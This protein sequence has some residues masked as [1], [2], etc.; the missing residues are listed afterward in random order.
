VD[1][2]A[3]LLRKR[4]AP[5]FEVPAVAEADDEASEMNEFCFLLMN[6]LL[7]LFSLSR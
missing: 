5:V 3:P 1:E 2:E 7:D 4:I 6:L